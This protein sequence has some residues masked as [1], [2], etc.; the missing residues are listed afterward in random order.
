MDATFGRGVLGFLPAG[1]DPRHPRPFNPGTLTHVA[2]VPST[3]SSGAAVAAVPGANCDPADAPVR[4]STPDGMPH[5][6]RIVGERRVSEAFPVDGGLR[7][8]ETSV[9]STAQD[10]KR[11]C[12]APSVPAG[13]DGRSQTSASLHRR[14]EIKSNPFSGNPHQLPLP[15]SSKELAAFQ[16]GLYLFG[17]EFR[18]VQKLVS[19]RTVRREAPSIPHPVSTNLVT[20]RRLPEMSASCC[21]PWFAFVASTLLFSRP[22]LNPKRTEKGE[23]QC[24]KRCGISLLM[25]CM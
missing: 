8:A 2:H 15:W 23:I 22:A 13:Y 19:T 9:I 10:I 25:L 20:E 3:P 4:T 14:L 6:S 11:S 16:T 21:Y 24:C 1:V 12:A 5:R 17:R 7:E 18:G